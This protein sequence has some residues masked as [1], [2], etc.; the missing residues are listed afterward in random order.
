MD[1][2]TWTRRKSTI[3]GPTFTISQTQAG[4]Y[5]SDD[6]IYAYRFAWDGNKYP[7]TLNRFFVHQKNSSTMDSCPCVNGSMKLARDGQT[8][9]EEYWVPG[10]SQKAELVYERHPRDID[11]ALP[12][13]AFTVTRPTSVAERDLAEH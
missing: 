4:M 5:R 7:A 1:S 8:W 12:P 3:P 2:G 11:R 13:S 6:G 10:D 9:I